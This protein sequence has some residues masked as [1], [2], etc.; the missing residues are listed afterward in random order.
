MALLA[1]GFS[2]ISGRGVELLTRSVAQT[3]VRR[4][5]NSEPCSLGR[6]CR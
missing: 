6:Y 4:E 2:D 5:E 3:L 1:I